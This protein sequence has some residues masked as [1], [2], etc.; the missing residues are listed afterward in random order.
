MRLLRDGD[1]DARAGRRG[2]RK[3]IK[4][5]KGVDKGKERLGEKE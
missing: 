4:G 2:K 1:L 5:M 3:G